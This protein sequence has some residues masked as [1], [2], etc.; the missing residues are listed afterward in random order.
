MQSRHMSQWLFMHAVATRSC[1]LVFVLG[2]RTES[3]VSSQQ[4]ECHTEVCQSTHMDDRHLIGMGYDDI[5]PYA[6]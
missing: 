2:R 3:A 1:W 6:T 5:L 4:A